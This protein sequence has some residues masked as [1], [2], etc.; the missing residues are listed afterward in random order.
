MISST[1]QLTVTAAPLR[2]CKCQGAS[3]SGYRSQWP[4]CITLCTSKM[5]RG[6]TTWPN[7]FLILTTPR[8]PLRELRC[9]KVS[10][11]SSRD[12]N[13]IKLRSNSKLSISKS[14]ALLIKICWCFIASRNNFMIQ[15]SP[16]V[17]SSQSR[18]GLVVIIPIWASWQLQLKRIQ[19]IPRW[20]DT[21]LS[22]LNQSLT[23][24]QLSPK[25]SLKQVCW[26]RPS[27]TKVCNVRTPKSLFYCWRKPISRHLCSCRTKMPSKFPCG[28]RWT[29]L[30]A[31]LQVTSMQGQDQMKSQSMMLTCSNW[32]HS[33]TKEHLCNWKSET[34]PLVVNSSALASSPIKPLFTRNSITILQSGSTSPAGSK[35]TTETLRGKRLNLEIN[36]R[37][38]TIFF[39]VN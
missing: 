31:A 19:V 12:W 30:I 34:R 37:L 11:A 18:F 7:L 35:A 16:K 3:G 6:E 32:A 25:L 9:S 13:I 2:L 14:K 33:T 29:P 27:T 23:L 28:L 39:K 20:L 36:F 38:V 17:N 4:S 10:M 15:L 8:K 26:I 5:L 1:S 22:R 21:D 24:T